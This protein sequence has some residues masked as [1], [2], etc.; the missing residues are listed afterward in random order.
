MK[1]T[2]II[3]NYNGAHFMEP[4]LASLK[5]QSCRDFE[6]LVVDKAST[7]GS[8][9]LLD[10]KYPEIRAIYLNK[11]YGFSKAVNVGIQAADTPY[12][13]LLNNDTRVD[14]HYVEALLKTIESSDRIFSV[15]SKMIQMYHP[16]LIDDAGDLYNIIGW[17]S[18]RGVGQPSSGYTKQKNI[19]SACGGASIYRRELFRVIGDFDEKHFA[20]L[21]D[22][23]I[24]YRA[25]IFG[26]RNVYC[27][28]A[29]VYHVGSGTSGS[30]YNAFKVKLAARN[31]IYL[32]Y[33][34]M[35]LLQLIV[36]S[37]FLLTGYLIKCSFFKKIGFGKEYRE[38]LAEGFKT[39][40][41]CHKVPFHFKNIWNYIRIEGELIANMFIYAVEYASRRRYKAAPVKKDLRK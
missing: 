12:V 10:E 29:I 35:P 39:V 31:S 27:P 7:D 13:I 15:S 24:G 28:D 18:Q 20:Y 14:D 30:R 17:A 25:R 36:N 34:N 22:T 40:S 4:C 32:N 19:F 2:V 21:E 41:R 37:P 1:V 38:G 16:E 33:K 23:D 3:A 5:G 9:E 11:N 26:Y 6:I 8:R